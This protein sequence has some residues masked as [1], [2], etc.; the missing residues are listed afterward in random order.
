MKVN[1]K[2]ARIFPSKRIGKKYR[3]R[4]RYKVKTPITRLGQLES[5]IKK[6][7]K[8]IFGFPETL[9]T[10]LRYCE[11]YTLTSASG[12]VAKQIMRMNSPYDPDQTNIGHQAMWVDTYSTVYN[13]YTVLGSKL[14]VTFCIVPNTTSTT[15]PSAPVTIGVVGDDDATGSSTVSTLCETSTCKSTLLA[16]TETKTMV[17]TYSPE[18]DLGLSNQDDTVGSNWSGNPSAQWYGVIWAAENGTATTTNVGIKVTVEYLV[19]LRQVK[20]PTGS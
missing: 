19:R 9:I 1:S 11:N 5:R 18:K 13:K 17:L 7:G 20:D 2:M 12:A 4:G 15:Q 10:R 16:P 6:P 14:T 3:P 8:N